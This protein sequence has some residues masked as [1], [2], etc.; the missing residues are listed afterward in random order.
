M[1]ELGIQDVWIITSCHPLGIHSLVTHVHLQSKQA[2]YTATMTTVPNQVV[3][4][5][6]LCVFTVPSVII[7][8][9][10]PVT[11]LNQN[12]LS[13]DQQVG[14][15]H[16]LGLGQT[17]GSQDSGCNISQ[18][19]IL[20]LQAPTLGGIGHDEGDLVGGV[21][22]LG[23]AIGERHLLSVAVVGGDKENVALFLASIKNLADRPICG[24][25]A[26]D[27]S[28]VHAS[29]A[30]HV[31][32]S[33]VVHDEGELLIGKTLHDLVCYAIG[34]HLRS[35]V[36]CCHALVRRDEIL[37]LVTSLQVERLFNT[38]VEEEGDMGVL[39]RLSHVYLLHVLLSEP[40]GKD[41]A[42]V[43]GLECNREG[44]VELVLCHGNQGGLGVREVRKWRSVDIAEK[45]G[46]LSHTIGS[47]VEE[48]D[49]IVLC[50]GSALVHREKLTAI[51][52]ATREWPTLDTSLITTNNDR[53]EELI[54]LSLFVSLLDGLDRVTALLA[55]AQN[56]TTQCDPNALPPLITVHGIVTANNRGDLAST[57]LLDVGEKLLHISGAG[58]GVGVAAVAKEVD[59]DIGNASLL[60]SLEEGIEVGLF[61]VLENSVR[62]L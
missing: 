31:G 28:L 24:F 15:S 17:H 9:N 34:T 50:K 1:A 11:G 8:S 45:L 32:R 42:H 40:L 13:L 35:Q 16:L 20:L 4:L 62:D 12:P 26:N 48:E 27:S 49:S 23:L 53:L 22:G 29:V 46:D 2:E 7:S 59:E 30:N 52:A 39:L 19:A 18:N 54:V 33:K 61:R 55:L 58:L 38:A 14:A 57:N 44:I 43:L 10:K 36:V 51:E 56:Q 5:Y 60:G 6:S 37:R 25:A 41:I 47:V 3:P 21:R